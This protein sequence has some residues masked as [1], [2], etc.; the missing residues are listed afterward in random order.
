MKHQAA[1]LA[2]IVLAGCTRPVQLPVHE[3][4]FPAPETWQGAEAVPAPADS[5]WWAY[6]GDP[7]LDAAI[8]QA[9]ECS[10]DL[11]AATARL[12]AASQEL[13]V[14]RAAER[15]DLGVGA[16]R[17]RQRQNFVG[18][19]FP[20]LADRVLSNTFTN[21]GL[22]FNVSWEVDLWQNIAAGRLVAE[23]GIAGREADLRAARLSLS[24]QV[25]KAWF[26]A[27]EA[28]EQVDLASSLKS[29]FEG[30]EELMTERYRAGSRSPVDLRLARGDVERA[31]ASVQERRQ[32]RDALVRQIEILVCEYP[33]GSRAT[34]EVLA[35][36]PGAVPAGLPSE[37]VQRRPDLAAAREALLA[38]DARG[39][40]AKAALLPSFA[41]TSALGTSSN[42][43]LDLVNPGLQVWNYALAM[44]VPLF[45]RGR[46]KANLRGAQAR[47]E[48]AEA[49][50]ERLMHNAFLEVETALS[51]ETA[52]TERE[53]TLR[54]AH[55]TAEEAVRLAERRYLAGRGDVFTV[56]ALKRAVI[57]S[58]S[59]LL[60]LHRTRINNRVDLH[61]ALGG[62]FAGEAGASTG[63]MDSGVGGNS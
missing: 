57:E 28:Q 36:V 58:Q 5:D 27:A 46:L 3:F 12:D 37:L 49:N 32:A 15:P 52:L 8:G 29:H 30:V 22:T 11:R 13:I 59:G 38:A 40:Q 39:V 34:A 24:G 1:A 53:G 54:R 45:N 43:L 63:Q 44:S 21:S 47:S 48:E 62:A 20:G 55:S 51:A 33:A 25:A 16:N 14:A 6:F 42:T 18:L 23:A 60:A 50:F 17:L 4:Q 7:G 31:I 2:A 61:L 35:K 19:P 41:L 9:L 56:L 10:Q 26:S